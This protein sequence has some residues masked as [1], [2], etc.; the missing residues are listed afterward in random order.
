[1]PAPVR[2]RTASACSG[3]SGGSTKARAFQ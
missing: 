2:G 1:V 3:A